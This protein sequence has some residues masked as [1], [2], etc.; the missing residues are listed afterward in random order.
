MEKMNLRCRALSGKVFHLGGKRVYFGTCWLVRIAERPWE[1]CPKL[2]RALKIEVRDKYQPDSTLTVP[3]WRT[4]WGCLK[5]SWSIWRT[6][7]C[8]V[9]M[10]VCLGI[11]ECRRTLR[12]P[13]PRASWSHWQF[14]CKETIE[15]TYFCF[16][17]HLFLPFKRRKRR[18]GDWWLAL[19]TNSRRVEISKQSGI[20][21]RHQ[22][23]R[24][25]W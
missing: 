14:P 24:R 12:S 19:K 2:L 13:H 1:M 5:T 25:S 9:P 22:R 4:L 8:V 11:Q 21:S 15:C 6:R 10:R 16:H 3:P 23:P 7:A 18:K 17:F 20:I